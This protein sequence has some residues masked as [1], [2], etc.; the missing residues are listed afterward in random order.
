MKKIEVGTTLEARSSCDYECIFR[1]KVI[2]RTA[3]RATVQIHGETKTCGIKVRD[4]VEFIMAL[5]S[6]SMA[7]IFCAEKAVKA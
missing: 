6:Y 2:S 1:A 5:G 7:P 3:K 4:G